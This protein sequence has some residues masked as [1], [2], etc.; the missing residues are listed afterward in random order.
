MRILA[1]VAVAGIVAG[2]TLQGVIARAAKELILAWT[3]VQPVIAQPATDEVVAPV[4]V[5]NVI[6]L[7]SADD[8]I[9]RGAH[10]HIGLGRAHQGRN[11][12]AAHPPRAW[13]VLAARMA[14]TKV[15]LP[16]T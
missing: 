1:R 16:W 2:A 15:Q 10:Q 4:A 5:Y 6:A 8:V 3:S 9:A 12:P 14:T 11:E 7:P 13:S